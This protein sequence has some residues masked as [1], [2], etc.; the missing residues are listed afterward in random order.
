MKNRPHP[1]LAAI[2]GLA[3]AVMATSAAAEPIPEQTV[4]D[5]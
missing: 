4:I 3:L 2:S 1:V 5:A